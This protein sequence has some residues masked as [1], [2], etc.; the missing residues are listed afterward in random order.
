MLSVLDNLAGKDFTNIEAKI[1]ENVIAYLLRNEW[2]VIKQYRVS[3]RW[4]GRRWYVDLAL[5]TKNDLVGIEIDGKSARRK[6]IYKLC[7]GNFTKKI[8]ILRSPF[9]IFEL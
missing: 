1:F 4:D 8:I 6:S 5:R 9:T 3:N 2:E 7:N